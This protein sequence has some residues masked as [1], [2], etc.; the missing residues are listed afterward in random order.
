[1]V[2]MEQ[3][4]RLNQFRLDANRNYDELQQIRERHMR[5]LSRVD[6]KLDDYHNIISAIRAE[7]LLIITNNEAALEVEVLT[8]FNSHDGQ[9]L[10][11]KI[12]I[13][14]FPSI[15]KLFSGIDYALYNVSRDQLMNDFVLQGR[16]KE[17][18]IEWLR[19]REEWSGM[20]DQ[21]FAN[22]ERIMER[23]VNDEAVFHF[24][25]RRPIML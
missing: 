8:M 18:V 2:N 14:G 19:N 5:S 13:P 23:F 25:K 1:M 9:V 3:L 15:Y 4:Q 16:L 12:D 10:F 20:F 24:L 21:P 17:L 11:T 6:S 7:M 22:A